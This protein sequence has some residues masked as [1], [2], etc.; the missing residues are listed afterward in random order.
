MNE[1]ELKQRL[2]Q[3]N[4][5]KKRDQRAP[6]K[7]LLILYTLAKYQVKKEKLVPYGEVKPRLT[8]LLMNF[9][10]KR[11]S[12]HPEQRSGEVSC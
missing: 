10:P 7:P 1:A 3:L 8:D 5:W 11:R 12:Y 9:G 2:Q 6:H 4:V